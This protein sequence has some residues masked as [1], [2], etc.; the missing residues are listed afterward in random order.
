MRLILGRT[1]SIRGSIGDV[2][3]MGEMLVGGIE[4][5]GNGISSTSLSAVLDCSV[6]RNV[7]LDD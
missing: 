5:A 4:S 7:S 2:A 6:I 1:S 3:M